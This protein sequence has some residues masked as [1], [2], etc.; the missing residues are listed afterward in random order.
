MIDWVAADYKLDS[1]M[2]RPMD[3][4]ARREFLRLAQYKRAFVK[5]VVTEDATEDELE[6]VFEQVAAV[7]PACPVFIQPVTARGEARPPGGLD[8]IR[9]RA[10]AMKRLRDVRVMPQ[11]HPVLG[12]K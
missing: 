3:D 10:L 7:D 1:A 4:G 8:L 5:I 6:Q 2:G 12:L 11:I 9:F